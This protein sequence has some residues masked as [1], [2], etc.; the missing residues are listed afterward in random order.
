MFA[1]FSVRLKRF[2]LR[3]LTRPR[4]D[5]PLLLALFL[6]ACAGLAT[7]YSA[8]N[9]NLSLVGG[10]AARFV[11]GLIDVV[12]ELTWYKTL[13]RWFYR[14][15]W[16]GHNSELEFL[17][18]HGNHHDAIPTGMI[19]VTEN[20]M[21]EGFC[22]SLIG[23]PV[24]YYNPFAASFFLSLLVWYDMLTHQYIPGLYPR[25]PTA[26]VKSTQH[27]THHFGQLA[28]YGLGS[29]SAGAAGKARTWKGRVMPSEMTNAI[30][31][32]E[33]LSGFVWDNPTFRNTVSLWERYSKRK[34]APDAEAV[35][36]APVQETPS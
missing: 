10:Q 2:G 18:L 12:I 34:P 23:P 4:L 3:L 14:E 29:K 11:L 25:L 7:L 22:R 30:K 6:L 1:N 32:D 21:L 26:V 8:G 13:N 9:A 36:A 31:L 15:H 28:P 20:G 27:S 19:A 24:A 17:Y 5:L 33:E 16:V 35:V